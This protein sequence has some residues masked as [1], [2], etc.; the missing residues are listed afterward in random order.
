MR[1]PTT[2]AE[3]IEAFPD[4]A[5]CWRFLFR[6]RWPRGFVCPR[7]R[8]RTGYLLAAR[9]LMQCVACHHQAS[10]TA[11]TVFHKTRLPLRTWL[12]AIFFVGRHKQGISAVQLQADA[13]IASYRAAW[14]LLHK[15]R[16]A[17]GREPGERLMGHVEADES[18]LGAPHEKGRRGGRAF[19]RKTLV[20]VV[21]ERRRDHGRV[22]LGVLD[23]HG[24]DDIGPFVRGVIDAPHTILHSDGLSAYGRLARAGLEHV[25]IVQGPDRSQGVRRLPWSHVIFSNLK[26]WLRGTFHGVSPAYLPRYLDEFSFR[27]D[28]RSRADELAALVLG[29][30]LRSDPMPLFRLRAELTA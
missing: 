15:L 25:R 13:G 8:H 18:Y 20:G 17:L 6:T 7:C 23:S 1:F 26:S 21:V 14:L 5:A 12:L 28:R 27:Y 11:G 29:R 22:R 24:F 4:E 2:L 9:R 19:G 30:A 3:F 10:V 16:T